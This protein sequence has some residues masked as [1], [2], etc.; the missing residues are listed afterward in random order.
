MMKIDVLTLFPTM[1]DEPL[2]H[3]I[4]GKARQSG[5]VA[6]AIHDIRDYTT[7]RHKS[8]DDAPFGGGEGMVLKPE[9][10]FRALDRLGTQKSTTILLSPQGETFDQKMAEEL[11]AL[12]HLILVCGHYEGVDERVRQ[13][14]VQRD[15]SLGDFIA[16]GGELPAL[17][18]IDVVCRLLPGVVGNDSSL[19][20]ETFSSSFF[21]YPTYTR[22]RI[23][24]GL[25][26]PE[27]LLSGNH[28]QIN[29]WRR[30]E[31]I[32]RTFLKRPDLLAR[33]ELGAE[34]RK[35]LQEI[36]DELKKE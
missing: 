28:A 29:R 23:Y 7:D 33:V 13:A 10:I 8:A 20:N 5:R 36:K 2:K 26:V 27:V 11:A 30:I 14:V 15:I 9:P 25:A 35:L 12:P 32:K 34:D 1:L 3:S 19:I 17:V 31:A 24:R 16:S 6:I 18:L 22:P 21:D 4:L